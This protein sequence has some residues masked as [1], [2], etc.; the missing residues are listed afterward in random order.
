MRALT[1]V[2]SCILRSMRQGVA[3]IVLQEARGT[4]SDGALQ[5]KPN[6]IHWPLMLLPFGILHTF[7]PRLPRLPQFHKLC[8]S[9]HLSGRDR[10]V[11]KLLTAACAMA[12]FSHVLKLS[13]SGHGSRHN[14]PRDRNA[15]V[16]FQRSTFGLNR[17][18]CIS[19]IRPYNS[20]AVFDSF[21]IR[22]KS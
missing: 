9:P 10:F 3:S 14:L 4:T 6:S 5:L 12:C 1:A 18:G 19:N 20:S 17:D 22:M 15:A 7:P 8:S 11:G 2:G 21:E 13:S 16:A